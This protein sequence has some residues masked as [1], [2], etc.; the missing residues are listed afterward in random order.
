MFHTLFDS[1]EQ[2]PKFPKMYPRDNVRNNKNGFS[3]GCSNENYFGKGNSII[4]RYNRQKEEMEKDLIFD[5]TKNKIKLV[6]Y[7]NGFILNNG[8]FRDIYFPENNEFLEEVEKG[9]IPQ[10]LIRKGIIDLGILLINRKNEMFRSP[11]YQSLPTSFESYNFQHQNIKN[12]RHSVQD[13]ECRING[14]SRSKTMYNAGYIPQTPMGTRNQRNN[15]F[16]NNN[17]EMPNKCVKKI[18]L[19]RTSS[20][21]KDKKI[22]TLQDITSKDKNDKKFKPFSGN[23]QLLGTAN[24]IDG[25]MVDC[26]K[27]STSDYSSSNNLTMFDDFSSNSQSDNGF[28]FDEFGLQNNIFTY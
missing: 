15:I 21:P 13:E 10:E 5:K 2:I 22:I 17:F 23:G 14:K 27:I 4:D 24:I 12:N 1:H 16:F 9:Q 11:L 18:K 6:V 7:R 25:I 28:T 3:I 20:L 26:E 19:K 8:Q